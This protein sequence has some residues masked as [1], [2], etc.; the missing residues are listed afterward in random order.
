M[1]INIRLLGGFSVGRA[2]G[3]VPAEAWNRRGAA[4]LVKLLALADGRRMHREQVMDA[5]WPDAPPASAANRLHKAA[6]F[7]R[8][9]TGHAD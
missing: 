2:R 5:L 1:D 4:A 8:R 9:A 7:V 3:D 6:H